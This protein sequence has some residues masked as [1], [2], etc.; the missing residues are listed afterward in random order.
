MQDFGLYCLYKIYLCILSPH[1]P[2]VRSVLYG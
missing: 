1:L 2:E